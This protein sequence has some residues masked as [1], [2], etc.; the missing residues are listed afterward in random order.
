MFFEFQHL[1]DSNMNY[2]EHMFVSLNYAFILFVSC[3]KAFI[4]SFIPDL[5]ATSTSECIIE[6]HNK[7][8]RHTMKRL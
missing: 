2:F 7:L 4:H 8:E 1:K 6:I 5:F 3:I